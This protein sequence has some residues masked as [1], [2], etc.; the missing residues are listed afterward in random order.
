MQTSRVTSLGA[1]TL[2]LMMLAASSQAATVAWWRF[3]GD[4]TTTPTDGT[5]LQDTN[6]RTAVQAAGVPAIDSSG[7]GNT[8]YTWD[9]NN[10]GHQYRTLVPTATLGD[11]SANARSIKNNGVNPASFSWSSKS[12]PS[13]TDLQTI[14]PLEWTIEASIRTDVVDGAYRTFVGREGN[15]V[16]GDTSA[17]PLYF[18]KTNTN[19]VRIAFVDA[20][21]TSWEALDST[22]IVANQWYHFAATSDGSTLKL[23]KDALDGNGYQLV[24]SRDISTSSDARMIDPGTDQNLEQWGWTVGRGRYGTS[25]D[26]GQNHGDRWFGY[27]DEVRISD[28]ALDPTE[29][30][31]APAPEPGT[32]G[33]LGV[34]GL[35]GLSRRRRA[36]QQ[37]G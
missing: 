2:G 15:G 10:T 22:A 1:S 16:T 37:R 23:F 3:E 9:N 14:T 29:F 26:P 32:V 30:V 25:D 20:T 27:I 11:G 33:V 34:V 7:N 17:A 19:R 28:S 13:G 36:S 31:F 12:N 18:Q 35:W 21:G 24:A 4:G 8:L 6:G 5:F